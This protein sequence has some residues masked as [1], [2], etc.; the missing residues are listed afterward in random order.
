MR[1]ALLGQHS[2]VYAACVDLGGGH[3]RTCCWFVCFCLRALVKLILRWL[4]AKDFPCLSV[5]QHSLAIRFYA[6]VSSQELEKEPE[7][8][9]DPS[10]QATRSVYSS[11]SRSRSR[12]RRPRAGGGQ[13]Q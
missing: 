9:M 2:R 6:I 12:T 7:A 1:T 10:D 4:D 11:E 3:I 8:E 5:A 13:P